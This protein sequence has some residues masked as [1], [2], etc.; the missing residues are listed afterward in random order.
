M[1]NNTRNVP[2]SSFFIHAV[3]VLIVGFGMPIQIIMRRHAPTHLTH[4]VTDYCVGE[5]RIAFEHFHNFPH[6]A[7][8]VY[9]FF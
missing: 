7:A 3:L 2:Y 4:H 6:C 5:D 8:C 9:L 1:D